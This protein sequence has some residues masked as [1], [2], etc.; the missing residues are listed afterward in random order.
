MTGGPCRRGERRGKGRKSLAADR[1]Q[2]AQAARR[3]HARAS[4]ATSRRVASG[5]EGWCA[6][7]DFGA[8]FFV[9]GTVT[10]TLPLNTA[11]STDP[12]ASKRRP[13]SVPKS[14]T[15]PRGVTT[16][17][18]CALAHVGRE[19]AAV[20]LDAQRPQ[21][22]DMARALQHHPNAAVEGNLHAAVPNID[23]LARPQAV[24]LGQNRRR[25]RPMHAAGQGKEANG[26]R[27]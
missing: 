4:P 1:S 21:N 17:N 2:P 11:T 27:Y 25:F 15:F 16:V 18:P 9:D 20:R 3:S 8:V 12:E 19:V 14:T 10:S 23:F 13:N 26:L 24:H 6:N 5:G 7:S 22:A